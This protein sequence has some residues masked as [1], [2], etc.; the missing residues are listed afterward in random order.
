MHFLAIDLEAC[1][2]YVKGSVFSIGVVC[3]DENF[4]IL[5]KRDIIINPKCKFATK[6]RKPIEFSID[7]ETV[8]DMPTLADIHSELKSLFGGDYLVVAHSAN[9]D[10]YMLNAACKRA[11]VP[12]FSFDYICTQTIYSAVYEEK[13]GI[14]LDAVAEKLSLTFTHHKADDDAEMALMLLKNCCEY[15]QCTYPE[16]EKRLGIIRGRI[17]NYELR[18]MRSKALDE[19]R[20]A[21]KLEHLAK[22]KRLVKELK[23]GNSNIMSVDAKYFDLIRAGIKKVE[24]RLNDEKRRQLKE[25][26]II[27]LVK[28][29]GKPEI[30]KSIITELVYCNSFVEVLERIDK[31]DMGFRNETELGFLEKL[32]EYYSVE[33][34]KEYGVVGIRFEEVS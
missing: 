7:K 6:F 5:Y 10:M 31:A 21:H 1:N 34:E 16:L 27:Y 11:N 28:K 29:N 20:K 18:P 13:N 24:L 14:G 15:M 19:M 12:A 23:K 8:K 17:D 22:Q 9:N 4:D 2:M 32:Y 3:A 26:D 30:I 33:K 25:G